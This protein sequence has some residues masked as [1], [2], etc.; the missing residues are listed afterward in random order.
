MCWYENAVI[1]KLITTIAELLLGYFGGRNMGN[2]LHFTC[3]ECDYFTELKLGAGMLSVNMSAVESLLN[4]EDLC[5]WNNLKQNN[6]IAFF[7]WERKLACCDN[8]KAL[9]SAVSVKIKTPDGRVIVIGNKCDKCNNAVR[10]VDLNSEIKCP[11]C[12]D[13][14]INAH[15]KGKWD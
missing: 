12:A 1:R 7:S 5:E 8:C 2:I 13:T 11:V 10:I 9:V 14:K 6:N 4:E 15:V 3:Q